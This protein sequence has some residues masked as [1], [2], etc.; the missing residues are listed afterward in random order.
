[1]LHR[2]QKYLIFKL[3]GSLPF[4]HRFL[5]KNNK[6]GEKLFSPQWRE[7][8]WRDWQKLMAKI[9]KKMFAIFAIMAKMARKSMAKMA[10]INGE[11]GEYFFRH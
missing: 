6:N 8:L 5:A 7:N 9:V 3:G 4:C 1:M 10:K 11:N 2:L